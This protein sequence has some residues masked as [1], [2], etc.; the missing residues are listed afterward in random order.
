MPTRFVKWFVLDVTNEHTYADPTLRKAD[1]VRAVVSR[2]SCRRFPQQ[3]TCVCYSDS[4]ACFKVF[5]VGTS[6]G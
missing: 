3:A 6:L 4:G 5:L 2:F 1:R